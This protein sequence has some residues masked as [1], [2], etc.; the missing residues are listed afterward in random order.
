MKKFISTTIEDRTRP[1]V[2]GER[3]SCTGEVLLFSLDLLVAFESFYS[4]ELGAN[5]AAVA[6]QMQQGECRTVRSPDELKN[7]LEEICEQAAG[8]DCHKE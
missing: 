5:L 2:D 4:D 1:Y 3:F 8:Q 7:H 6:R